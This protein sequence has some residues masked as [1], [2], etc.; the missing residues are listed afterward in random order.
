MTVLI[1]KNIQREGPG[2]IEDT[3]KDLKV[4]YEIVE[5]SDDLDFN[6]YAALIILGGPDSANDTKMQTQIEKIKNYV[7]QDKYLLG[8]NLGMHN[9]AK[10]FGGKIVDI[11]PKI[12]FSNISI[13]DQGKDDSIFSSVPSKISVFQLNKQAVEG[14]F[15]VLAS[16]DDSIQ[17]IKVKNSYG[18]QFHLEMTY[19]LL[20]LLSSEDDLLRPISSKVLSDYQVISDDYAKIGM[21][22]IT[23]F[24]HSAN[25]KI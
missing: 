10:A 1:V 12:G 18:F 11:S 5:Y 3:L 21:Q 9:L 14:D 16:S 8:I 2:L 7:G 23:N 4:K 22:I 13:T 17:A 20:N 19:G 24:L 6:K 25:I 15:E